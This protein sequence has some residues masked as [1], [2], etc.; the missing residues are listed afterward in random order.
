MPVLG[1]CKSGQ[2]ITFASFEGALAL[3]LND[4]MKAAAARIIEGMEWPADALDQ[5]EREKR[6]AL[7]D[8]KIAGAENELSDL[9]RSARAAGI[10]I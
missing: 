4:H 8:D 2:A 3:A 5:T 7:L 1:A 9:L 10:N 6:L